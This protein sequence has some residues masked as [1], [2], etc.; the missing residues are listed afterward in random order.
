MCREHDPDFSLA[1]FVVIK[2]LED[3]V[4]TRCRV[5]HSAGVAHSFVVLFLS[6]T[7]KMCQARRCIPHISLF[8]TLKLKQS[9]RPGR[10]IEEVK[11]TV[12]VGDSCA[13][14]S[15]LWKIFQ[16]QKS[17]RAFIVLKTLGDGVLYLELLSRL[18]KVS[19]P[20]NIRSKVELS[21][22]D[23][24]EDISLSFTATCQDG[25]PLPGLRKCADLKIG[26]TVSPCPQ[27]VNV[28]CSLM[29]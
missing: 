19:S 1:Q 22:W 12:S 24:P 10:N 29:A 23:H 28:S 18:D 2:V 27:T 15:G 5:P 11:I 9:Y 14:L 26:D 21:V 4:C 3:K 25:K 13:P 6:L 7:V 16:L 8:S 20:Q 17:L